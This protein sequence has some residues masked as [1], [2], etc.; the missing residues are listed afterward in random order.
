[1][2][3]R[4]GSQATARATRG[5]RGAA[6]R[7]QAN[8]D[9]LHGV[10]W[11]LIGPF[12]GGRVIAVH[13]DPAAAGVFYFGSTGG[14][15]WKTTDAGVTWRNVSDGAFT[16]A[17]VGALDVC[18]SDP[19]VIYVGTGES[20]I[21]GNVAQGD[22]VYKSTDAG[23]SWAHCGLAE[24][25]TIGKVR[26]HPHNPDLVYVAAFGHVFGPNDER[27]V[28]RSK[29]G[30]K[31]WEQVLSR[32][33][34]AGAVDLAMDP[35]NPRVLYAAFWEAH[36]TPYLLSS[37]GPGSGLFKSIDGGDTWTDLTD[38]PGM[39]KGVKGKI[40]VD[41]SR[42]QP[43]RVWALVEAKDG[44]LFR[45]DDGGD[46]WRK[47]NDEQEIRQRAWY[48]THVIADPQDPNT[49]YIPNVAF[50]KSTDGGKS[51]V[52]IPTPHG[53]DHALWIDPT[54]NR[55]MIEGN[56][57][58]A[59][60]T[61]DG[62]VS[63]SSIFNQPTAEFYHVVT[64]TQTP[65]RV[66]GAQ[67]DNSTLSVPSRSDGGAITFGE[68]YPVGGGES[69]YIAVRPDDPNVVYA[70]SYGG[71]LTRYDYRTRQT[72]NIS[73]WPDNPM[74]W[75]AKDLK[76]RF[77]W[78]YPIVLSPHDPD[79]IYACSQHVHRSTDEGGSWQVI[80]PDLTRNDTAKMEPSGGPITKDSTSVEYYGTVFAFAESP[81]QQGILW[82]GSDDGM[83]HVSRDDGQTWD[84]V[85]PD[86]RVLPEWALISIIEPSPHDAA[87]AYVAANR[88]KLDDF[89]PYFLK[90]A[91]SGKTWQRIAKGIPPTEYARTIREDPAQRG[92]LYAGTERGVYVSFDDGG[93]WQPL[94]GNLP[95]V[96]VHDLAVKD[97]DLVAATHGRSFWILDDLA[98][99]HQ[100]REQG[101]K[102][103]HLF[104][105][106]PTIRYRTGMRRI[107]NNPDN[108]RNFQ[109]S[110][111]G[112]VTSYQRRKPNG[113]EE[114]TFL[115]A[116]Q[117]PPAGVVV[118]YYFKEKPDKPVTL[119]F[120]DARGDVIKT[121][122]SKP[123]ESPPAEGATE[124][125]GPT[126]GERSPEGG[127]EKQEPTVP[128]EAGLNRF[129][130]NLRYP[131]ARNVK[132]AVLWAGNVEGPLAPPGAYQV[133][134]GV[135]DQ[136][137][138]ASFDLLQ[139]PRVA[140]TQQDLDEQFSFLVQIRDKLTAAHDAVNQLRAIRQQAD[141]WAK[142]AKGEPG[143]QRVADEAKA[144]NEKLTA[145]E[146]ELI[147]SRSKAMEDPLNFPIKLNNKL[148]AL[149]GVVASADA[150][151]TQQ[152]RDVYGELAGRIDQQVQRLREVA[153]KDV[154]AFNA[155]LRREEVP[156]I[157]PPQPT[158]EG[159]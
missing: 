56:D 103:P 59:C 152:A 81:V 129:V 80:S 136:T 55:R 21:R 139:D 7:A 135:D 156:A 125:P 70:G 108:R 53:D 46:T 12:R 45:S 97:G 93:S 18:A 54:D 155:T 131:D 143:E 99:V 84:D 61:F 19:N 17:S 145:I 86:Q 114:L 77:Q 26:V 123:P 141:D 107:R 68:C 148:A 117:N 38:R 75:G 90:T 27:G 109:G 22:G 58:G 16:S 48:Y 85:T 74:G 104:T 34:K 83:L 15:V 124:V 10:E 144:L 41:V 65:Y 23:K 120:K 13:G 142:R 94:R 149:S 140:A 128:V 51:F 35:T 122:K 62:G 105:P 50:L 157:V 37:G 102:S 133:E 110:G 88:Y 5:G 57:G 119:T 33:D 159:K 95:V 30:G 2:P 89:A 100:L 32:G 40:G 92:T 9:V 60:V 42:A 91:D 130:W 112:V 126:P 153:D 150:A 137:A 66:Y 73:P 52:S 96:P 134:L 116:G 113:E 44:G 111:G 4:R 63:W 8:A 76:Y 71:L 138:T 82:A 49:V 127:R 132:G 154:E 146:E 101:A 20:T 72:R 29:D 151:P 11:R 64:D 158:E 3:E 43:E 106:R 98:L 118:A 25:Q 47:T 39:P 121:F 28:Y 78:T 67:Q 36:R 115:D 31:T 24:T 87:T 6:S 79:T 1:M 147:Q 69:G 14:G